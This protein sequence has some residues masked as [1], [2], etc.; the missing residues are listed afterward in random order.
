MVSSSWLQGNHSDALI[1]EKPNAVVNQ[2]F[3]SS[4]THFKNLKWTFC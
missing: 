1:K 3:I 4:K 2:K